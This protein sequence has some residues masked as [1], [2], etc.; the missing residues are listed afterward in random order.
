[1]KKIFT[2]FFAMIAF[3]FI[4]SSQLLLSDD[5]NYSGLLTNNGW[6]QTSTEA[7]DPISTI[8]PGL[9]YA[10]YAGSGVGN[11]ANVI[12]TLQ[13]VNRG[14]TK[15]TGDGSVVWMSA[16]IRVTDAANYTGNG[17]NVLHLGDRSDTDPSG[18]TNFAARVYIK[19]NA[20][21]VAIGASNTSSSFYGTTVYQRN[22][23]YLIIV[24]Y[25]I[26]VA[27]PDGLQLWVYPS[28]VPNAEGDL[29]TPEVDNPGAG[30]DEIDAV[31]IRQASNL[32]DVIIDG[33]RIS[34]NYQQISL[35]LNL[36]SFKGSLLENST[37]LV[38]SSSNEV[39]VKDFSIERSND[40]RNFNSIGTVEAKN[41]TNASYTFSDFSPSLGSNYYRLKMNDKDG[42]FKYS[43]VVVINNR[44]SQSLSLFP[45][46]AVND[47][48]LNHPKAKPGAVAI[49]MTADG[50]QLKAI[51]IESGSL[52]TNISLLKINRGHY[53]LVF[54][55]AGERS[56]IKFVKQ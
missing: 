17:V 12:G 13:D 32:P 26:N 50:R 10:G 20:T 24:K 4:A 46:P 52:Q 1:M 40:G 33:I 45:N 23:T 38:W 8:T 5:F 22:T 6:T 49:I 43:Y 37:R 42:L 29:G 25:T 7:G 14:F 53:L 55:N 18:L 34:N 15:Q 19:A 48:N 3:S 2:L 51:P 54:D 9:T 31:G 56:T 30:Q 11:A 16:L 28:G 39:N 27:T 47:L 44:K 41:I 21:G 36:T 35:P